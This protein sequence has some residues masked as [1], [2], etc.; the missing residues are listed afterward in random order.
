MDTLDIAVDLI[1]RAKRVQEDEKSFHVWSTGEK[2]AVALVLNR[3]DLL[4]EVNGGY[5]I[6]EAIDRV[7][8]DWMRAVAIAE[9]HIREN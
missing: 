1:R 2:L 7:G 4:K 9:K 6:M 8:D 5:T 3:P